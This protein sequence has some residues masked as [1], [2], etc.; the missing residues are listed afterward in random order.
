MP[1]FA[2]ILSPAKSL[3][4]DAIDIPAGLALSKPRF[5]PQTREIAHE[6]ADVSA[7]RLGSLMSI[8]G[9]LA[10]LNHRRW[11]AFGTPRNPRGPAAMCFRGDVYQGLEA[12]TMKKAS[13]DWAQDHVRILSGLYGLLRPLDLIQPYRLEMGT[14]LKIGGRKNLYD[15]WQDRIATTLEKDM[16]ASGSTTLV[17][18]ASDEYS[19]AARLGDLSVPVITAKFLQIDAGKTK[20]MAFYAKQS[21]GLMARWMADHRPK[22]ITALRKFNAEGYTLSDDSTDDTLV[23]TRPK[24]LPIAQR[25]KMA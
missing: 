12:W 5:A 25:R 10:E 15:F 2:A 14:R 19:K 20:F 11:A 1:S 23:F 22:T 3:E 4:M 8:S 6:L 18:L 7:S 13:I 21:R 17:N 9:P 24:P 16:A